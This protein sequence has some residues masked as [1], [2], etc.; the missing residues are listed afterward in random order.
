MTTNGVVRPLRSIARSAS[1]AFSSVANGPSVRW[2]FA[3][4]SFPDQASLPSVAT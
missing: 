1:R 2:A 3:A 4:A